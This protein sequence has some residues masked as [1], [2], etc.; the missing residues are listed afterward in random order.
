M[1][2]SGTIKQGV[3]GVISIHNCLPHSDNNIPLRLCERA[4]KL[5]TSVHVHLHHVL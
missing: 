5:H 4:I 2:H 3:D 1:A